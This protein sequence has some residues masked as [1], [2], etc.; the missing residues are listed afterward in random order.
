MPARAEETSGLIPIDPDVLVEIRASLRALESIPPQLQR[1]EDKL[2]MQQEIARDKELAMES[3]IVA[4]EKRLDYQDKAHQREIEEIRE[5]H[6]REWREIRES[7]AQRER[8][9]RAREAEQRKMRMAVV[10]AIIVFVIQ[11]LINAAGWL[12]PGGSTSIS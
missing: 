4:I 2:E 9:A 3:R 6:K 8:E 10:T 12:A 11:A 5:A 7:N 1:L